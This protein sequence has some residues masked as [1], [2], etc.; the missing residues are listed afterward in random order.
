MASRPLSLF[1]LSLSP[2]LSLSPAISNNPGNFYDIQSLPRIFRKWYI[3]LKDN[4]QTHKDNP[5]P[6]LT[7]GESKEYTCVQTSFRDYLSF[8]L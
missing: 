4:P 8:Y 6:V 5:Q 7:I 2:F 1:S 3:H